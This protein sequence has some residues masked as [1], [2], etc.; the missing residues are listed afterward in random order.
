[1]HPDANQFHPQTPHFT[2]TERTTACDHCMYFKGLVYRSHVQS[3]LIGHDRAVMRYNNMS[4]GLQSLKSMAAQEA[5]IEE[6]WH[7]KYLAWCRSMQNVNDA[8]QPKRTKTPINGKDLYNDC[9]DTLT[10]W[11]EISTEEELSFLKNPDSK[12]DDMDEL[13]QEGIFNLCEY[14]RGHRSCKA[15]PKKAIATGSYVS[16]SGAVE[17]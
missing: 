16:A 1:M 11:L 7:A 14:I 5:V 4:E 2:N 15:S 6:R 13:R 12:D 17:E 3:H 10:Q 8:A 9:S